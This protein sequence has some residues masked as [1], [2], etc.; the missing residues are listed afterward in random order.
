MVRVGLCD[1]CQVCTRFPFA[2]T[3]CLFLCFLLS[4][5]A[6]LSLYFCLR[7]SFSLCVSL[8]MSL[9]VCFC[10]CVSFSVISV[11]VCFCVSICFS[12]SLCVCLSVS[13][14]LCVGK[15]DC[16]LP[17]SKSEPLVGLVLCNETLAFACLP[18]LKYA[19][20]GPWDRLF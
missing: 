3:V 16:Q 18:R 5:Y 6:F 15:I 9:C 8:S 4:V 7:V 10:L 19:L 13:L 2:H 20:I 12:L 11:S 14:S 1:I 17:H